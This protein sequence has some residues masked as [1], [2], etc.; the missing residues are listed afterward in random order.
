MRELSLEDRLFGSTSSS[1]FARNKYIYFP[2]KLVK[3][4]NNVLEGLFLPREPLYE[5]LR[6]SFLWEM[7]KPRRAPEVT[8]ES[9]GSFISRRFSPKVAQNLVSP[10]LHGI[11]AGDLDR[12]SAKSVLGRLWKTEEDLGSLTK[13]IFRKEAI[14]CHPS[15][16][17][18]IYD[19][20]PPNEWLLK[21][22]KS[23]LI[24]RFLEGME[25]L[26]K[27]LAKYLEKV[28]NVRIK[29]AAEVK[30]ITQRR[31]S[32]EK[33]IEVSCLSCA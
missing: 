2:D 24:L 27:S 7:S 15:D 31:N 11:Y 22:F 14:Y 12:L 29:T 25:A 30:A 5:G 8:D 6:S 26:P 17:D 33:P 3:L 13:A 19:L 32:L 20:G 4:P 10:V 16:L 21:S 9:V 23:A 28:P 1:P 18:L